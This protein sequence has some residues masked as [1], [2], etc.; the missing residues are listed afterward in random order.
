MKKE[1][2][3]TEAMEDLV[4][5]TL[6]IGYEKGFKEGF[7]AGKKMKGSSFREGYMTAKDEKEVK[8]GTFYGF[9]LVIKCPID[10]DERIINEH[11]VES[12]I[13]KARQNQYSNDY[14]K[15]P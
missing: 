13:E 11:T 9:D 8:Q 15:Q 14:Y 4:E 1:K 3:A 6:A 12:Y 2:S 10:T 7:E 5:S